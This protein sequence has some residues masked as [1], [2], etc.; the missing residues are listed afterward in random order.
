MRLGLVAPA[1]SHRSCAMI[2][3]AQM[4]NPAA[5]SPVADGSSPRHSDQRRIELRHAAIA[6]NR[7][8]IERTAQFTDGSTRSVRLEWEGIT[9]VG[10]FR[11]DDGA[12]AIVCMAVTDRAKVVIFDER[13]DGWN[14]MTD[15]LAEFLP[16]APPPSGWRERVIQPQA[17]ANWTVLFQAQ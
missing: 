3:C 2:C 16:G 7:E 8:A 17:S 14:S 6:V 10:A 13:M 11:C 12:A 5:N 1:L 9:R 15:A 4:E